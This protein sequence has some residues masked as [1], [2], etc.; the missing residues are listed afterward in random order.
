[1]R[2][3]VAILLDE[4]VRAAL[5]EEIDRLRPLSRTVAW[6]PAAN[7]HLTLHFLGEQSPARAAEAADAL[8]DA[9]ASSPRFTLSVHGL[10]AF[11]GLDR[12]RILWTGVAG[13]AQEVRALQARVEDAL[14]RRGFAREARAWHP[15]VTLG[16]VFDDRRWRRDAGAGLQPAIARGAG[17]SFGEFAVTSIALMQSEL[18]RGGALYHPVAELSLGG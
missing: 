10:G 17:R 16:R 14:E 15:H 18:G 9:A 8:T 13:G 12:A 2:C 5:A 4:V 3:F 7:L 6:V 11:P 1:V